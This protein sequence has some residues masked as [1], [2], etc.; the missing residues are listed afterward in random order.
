M[1]DN[2]SSLWLPFWLGIFPGPYNH[3]LPG[4]QFALSLLCFDFWAVVS[5]LHSVVLSFSHSCPCSLSSPCFGLSFL[6]IVSPVGYLFRLDRPFF[7]PFLF[8]AVYILAG[9]FSSWWVPRLLLSVH[10]LSRMLK[11]SAAP[12]FLYI[13][14]SVYFRPANMRSTFYVALS[15]VATLVAADSPNPFNIPK[16]GYSF[17]VGEPTTLKWQPNSDGTVSLKLQSGE[18]LTPDGGSTIACEWC[19]SCGSREDTMLT[20]SSA[21]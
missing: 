9:F 2:F 5:R 10:L 20:G 3:F 7:H 21:H 4:P 19:L 12:Y 18:V 16:G 11:T 8:P 15:A 1:S 6:S 14:N 17:T 13:H